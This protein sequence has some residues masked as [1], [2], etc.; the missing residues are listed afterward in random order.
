MSHLPFWVIA[1]HKRNE[2]YCWPFL[3]WQN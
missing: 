3:T 1:E 2:V